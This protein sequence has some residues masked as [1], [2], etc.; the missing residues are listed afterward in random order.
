MVTN[1]ESDLFFF[2]LNWSII[3]LQCCV[4]FCC[5]KVNQLYIYIYPLPLGSPSHSTLH[6]P[7][8]SSQSTQF[9]LQ[10]IDLLLNEKNVKGAFEQR[11]FLSLRSRWGDWIPSSA[12]SL[13]AQFSSLTGQISRHQDSDFSSPTPP[14]LGFLFCLLVLTAYHPTHILSWTLWPHEAKDFYGA[15]SCPHA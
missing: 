7:S 1:G 6:Y 10:S 15:V 2:F 5:N 9:G 8:R 14:P 3:A 12:A 4:S 11:E 13:D